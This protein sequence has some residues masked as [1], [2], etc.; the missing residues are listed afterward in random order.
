MTK[1]LFVV[2]CALVFFLLLIFCDKNLLNLIEILPESFYISDLIQI[3]DVE[4]AR[5]IS[6]QG[7]LLR[8]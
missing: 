1:T 6:K 2:T 3:H 4:S 8:P 5:N 7:H